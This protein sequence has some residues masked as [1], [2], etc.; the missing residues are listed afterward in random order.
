MFSDIRAYLA[1]LEARGELRTVD[2]PLKARRGDTELQALMRHLHDGQGGPALVLNTVEGEG[3]PAKVLFNTFGTRE[4]AAMMIGEEGWVAGRAKLAGVLSDRKSWIKPRVVEPEGAPCKEVVITDVD[5]GR[6]LPNVWF[7]QEGAAYITGAIVVTKDVETGE[8]NVGWYRLTS[9]VDAAHPL[10][11]EYPPERSRTDLAGFFWWN[12]P[13]SGVGMHIA[14]AFAAGRRLEIACAVMCDPAVHLAAATGL[15]PGVDE[16]EFA[17]GLRGAAVDLVKCETVDLEVPAGA[18]WVIEGEVVPGEQEP[19]GWHSN[20]VGY[21][22]RAHV[23]P[24]VR[25]KAITRRRDAYWY[26][27]MEMMPPFD[28]IYLGLM[29]FEAELLSDIQGKIPQVQDVVVTPNLCYVVQLSVDGARKPHAEFGKYVLHAVWGAA[30]RWARTAKLVIVVGPDV[31]PKDWAQIEWAIMTRVQ[32]WS[33]VI[34]NRSGQAML[35]DPSAPRNAQGAASV[36]EQMG[37]DATIKV[38]ERFTEYAETSNA[39]PEAVRAIAAKLAHE[40]A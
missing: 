12:P 40:L 3:A 35:L 19:I 23:L 26:A 14:K 30:G 8:R 31:D 15:P 25:V 10:G 5:L 4:R 24:I 13:G 1:H 36:S 37:I 2:T 39:S 38:P 17:G 27:T 33:D 7:G 9:F 16:F 34:V 18:E 6:D 29:P 21:Y 11:G 32:P 20:P 28:H 22:D